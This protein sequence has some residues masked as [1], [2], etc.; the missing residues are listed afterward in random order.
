MKPVYLRMTA[1]AS[2]S[3]TAEVDFTKL[4][5]DGIFLITGKTGGGKT[6]ILDAICAS[7]YGKAT[8]SVRGDDWR[9]LRCT[10]A[11]DSRDTELEYVFSVGNIKYRFYRRWHMPN[12]KKGERRLDDKEN[13]CSRMTA[14]SDEWECISTGSS[15]AL[16]EAAESILSLTHDQFVKLIM[17][18]QGEFRELLIANDEKKTEIFKKLFDTERWEIITERIKQEAKTIGESCDEQRN[19]RRLALEQAKCASPDEL[20]LRINEITGSLASLAEKAKRNEMETRQSAE[21]LQNG[22]TLS[23]IFMELD[24]RRT[25]LKELD[26]MTEQ[27]GKLREK[28]AHSRRLR[29][30]LPEYGMMNAAISEYERAGAALEKSVKDKS[31]ADSRL[32]SATEKYAGIPEL[33]KRA[34][35]LKSK[36][37]NLGELAKDSAKHAQAKSS[38]KE[39]TSQLTAAQNDLKKL[40]D[41]KKN[42]EESIKNGEEYLRQFIEASEALPTAVQEYEQIKNALSIA[43][44]YEKK[45]AALSEVKKKISATETEISRGETELASQKKSVEVMEQAIRRDM[46]YSLASGLADGAPCP[47]CGAMHHPSPAQ[48]SASTPTAEQL[49]TCR[50]LA[51]RTSAE[52]ESLRKEHSGLIAEQGILLRDISAISEKAGTEK[53]KS[54]S[55]LQ[56]EA[57]AAEGRKARLENQAKKVGPARSKIEEYNRKLSAKSADIKNA[58]THINNLSIQINTD[59]QTLAQLDGRLHSHSIASFEEL[60]GIL[61]QTAADLK[62]TEG[63][64]KRITDAFNSAKNSAD[65]AGVLLE[66]ARESVK[67]AEYERSARTAEFTARCVQL[68]IPEDS[69]FKNGILSEKDESEFEGKLK[70]YDDKLEFARRRSAEL[71]AET[72]DKAR[73]DMEALRSANKSALDAGREIARQKGECDSILGSLKNCRE[74]VKK[75]D[76][77]LETLERKY[78]TA[79]RICSLLSNKNAAKTSIHRYVIGIKMDEIIIQANQYLK[80]LTRG[81]YAM[82][83]IE[84]GADKINHALDIE[85]IDGSAGGIRPVSTLS[86]GEMFLASL[87]L[88]FGLSETVQSFAGGIHLDSLFIDE[89][90]GSL[91]SETLDTA[92]EA[93]TRV[94]DN[95]LL[96]I[97][98]HVTELQERIPCG[99]EV[100]KNRDGSSLRIR[101]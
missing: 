77:A 51:D 67:R 7:L 63:E 53:I 26:S 12:S 70:E 68:G 59:N 10:D 80:R 61:G 13:V 66:N 33:E 75:A 101:K 11:P 19:I 72:A 48:P 88:A 89:G 79:Q 82:R 85:I 6:T 94:R 22:E 35:S 98:S 74:T 55:A 43:K 34:D 41:E 87:A 24:A 93:I 84:G 15:K 23:K 95:R 86:G 71:A 49:D 65:S 40:E 9:Q 44:D 46:A 45:S 78:G 54:P 69:D 99:I 91:D 39:H 76:N 29:G 97:I 27:Y 21:A 47:V 18:P 83:R 32:L 2:Y 73:P 8:G 14:G 4:Y 52:L 42:L 30:V 38:L 31:E 90:F 56:T 17:L 58:E 64:I 5:E 50:A 16:R 36:S 60:K 37:A 25:E 62:K 3:G 96:G 92:M 100:V 1:F 57:E 28:L 81:Q 20:E